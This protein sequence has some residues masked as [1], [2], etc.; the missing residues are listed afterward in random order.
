LALSVAFRAPALVNAAAVNSDAA[1]VGLQAMHILRGEWS[2]LLFGSSYQ[3]SVDSAVAALFFVPGGPGP[4]ALMLSTLA[5]HVV[6]TLLVYAMLRPRL[7]AWK[8]LV[9]ALPLVFAPPSV[10]TYVLHPPRQA[11]LTLGVAGLWALDRASRSRRT[12]AWLAVGGAA[13]SLACFADPY[14]LVLAPGA[15]LLALLCAFDG[16]PDAR[17]AVQRVGASAIG[18]ALGLLPLAWLWSYPGAKHG[19]TDL[20]LGVVA[21][22]WELL[23]TTCLPWGLSYQAW[24][25]QGGHW[26]PWAAP[27]AVRALQIAGAAILVGGILFGALALRAK[28][29]PWE[30]RRLGLAGCAI[31]AATLLGF[32]ASVMVMDAFSTRYL[33]AV[34]LAAPLAL[35]PL[36]SMLRGPRFFALLAPYLASAALNGW[37]GFVPWVDGARI[38]AT[39]DGTARDERALEKELASRG[40]AW[41]MADYWVSYRLTFLFAERVVVVPKNLVEDRY[42]PYRVGFEVAPKV[43]YVFDPNRSREDYASIPEQ[44]RARGVAFEDGE[45]LRVGRLT[46]LV[47]TRREP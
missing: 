28:H 29:A 43:A 41:A 12:L 40:V 38:V 45:W 32:L 16:A 18:A 14:A 10:H 13:A 9:A 34:V 30:A 6:L 42:A 33:A 17:M 8:A 24:S 35:A 15:A 3:T 7:G 25:E 20:T 5:G 27:P 46:A 11:A 22:N 2:P 37:M 47:V 44:L 1:I 4:G 36:A 31:C 26:A 39:A 23:E 19:T 21:H